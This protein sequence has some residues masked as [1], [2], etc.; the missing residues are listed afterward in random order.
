MTLDQI[1]QSEAL[2][3]YGKREEILMIDGHGG[4]YT[5]AETGDPDW[6][7]NG[8]RFRSLRTARAFATL[9]PRLEVIGPDATIYDAAWDAAW[10]AE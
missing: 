5:V 3:D 4:K 2:S 1:M 6:S 10:D 9:R 8:R 7:E